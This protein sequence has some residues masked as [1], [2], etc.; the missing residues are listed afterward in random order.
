[1]TTPVFAVVGRVNKGKS[2]VVA[3]LAEDPAVAIAPRPGTTRTATRFPVAVDGRVLFELVDTPGFEEADRALAWLKAEA[4]SPAER[5][6]RVRHFVDAHAGT[7]DFIEERT[8]LAP[9]LR[10]ASILYV[11]DGAHPYRPNHQAEMEI[12]RWTGRPGM[13]LI[14]RTGDGDHTE[15]WR[16]ALKQSFDVVRVFDAHHASF[17]E[18]IALF[19]AFRALDD[20]AGPALEAAIDALLAERRRRRAEAAHEI[21]DLLVDATTLTLTETAPDQADLAGRRAELEARFHA[22]LR[23]R[24]QAAR[25]RVEQLY[26]HRATWT[27]GELDR[28]VF[29]EDLFAERTWQQLGLTDGQ[30]IAATTS[31]GA[32]VGG[33]I[34]AAVGGASFLAGTAIGA[35]VGLF[36]GLA[37]LGRRYATA[38]PGERA[39]DLGR[40]LT[41]PGGRPYR[42]GPHQNPNFPFI[43]LDRALLHYTDVAARA[44]ARQ[45]RPRLPDARPSAALDPDTR[46]ALAA[47]FATLRKTWQ[48]VDHQTRDHLYRHVADRLEAADPAAP[49]AP[50][51]PP[52]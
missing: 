14:N 52:S 5:P 29:D 41:T 49:I 45:D 50:R 4:V 30:I 44:H 9:I 48:D 6:A 42:I 51:L 27:E 18:R 20:D 1:M 3:T 36:G 37:R 11:V 15:T 43:L 35:A 26:H 47:L 39:A 38:T 34:D 33:A 19:R 7:D 46:K 13:A 25:R 24:E 8:L 28:P 31:A 2:S 32:A 23:D 12:L 40:R 17:A 21:T 22:R 10:G 16:A